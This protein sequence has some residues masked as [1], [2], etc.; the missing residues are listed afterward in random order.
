MKKLLIIT[1]ALLV[2]TFLFAYEWD[3]IGPSDVQVNNFNTVYY[4][5]LIEILCTSDGII[6]NDGDQWVEYTYS[7]LPAWS[8]VGLDSNNILV[9]LGD[10]SFSDGVY[11]F[12]LTTHQFEV[13]E[14]VYKPYFLHYCDYDS[15][16]YAGGGD[17]MWKSTNGEDFIEIEYFNS[18][19]CWCFASFDD[20]IVVKAE[21]R[22]YTSYDSGTTWIQGP[23]AQPSISDM[24]FNENGILYGIMPGPSYSSGLWSSSN[25]GQTWDIE[26]WNMNMTSVGIDSF[27]NVYV[28]WEENDFSQWNPQTHQLTNMNNGL[29][30]TNINKIT[31]HGECDCN[32]IVACTD[33]GAYILLNPPV[34]VDEL[35]S[36]QHNL[37]NYPNPF[38]NTTTVVFS[39]NETG[40]T[41][42]NVY[43]LFGN[44]VATLFSGNAEAGHEYSFIF[45]GAALSEG[46]YY[47]QLQSGTKIYIVEKM[48][49]VK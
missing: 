30:N 35:Q 7:G 22:F 16:Y 6:I 24:N 13:V 28:G 10:G 31:S 46:V 1:A 39:V 49:L 43:D 21:T 20:V 34:H 47:Y 17:G 4:N 27:Q 48:V 40:S 8:A 38:A 23:S 36:Q 3:S 42:L 19:R 32:N 15:T 11:K 5:V 44:K 14:W 29:P 37:T 41:T 25:F 26:F 18:F 33:G 45:S 2:S 9:L 12:N